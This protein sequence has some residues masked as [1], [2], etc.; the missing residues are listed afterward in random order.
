[1]AVVVFVRA[2]L[3]VHMIVRVFATGSL[4]WSWQGAMAM[5]SVI[6]QM[7]TPAKYDRQARRVCLH[8]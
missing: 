1:M 6:L 4:R 3:S 7:S 8:R 5:P 2:L